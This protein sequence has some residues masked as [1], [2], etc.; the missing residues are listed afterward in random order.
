MKK[1][2]IVMIFGKRKGD[3]LTAVH[4]IQN[5][6]HEQVKN[7]SDRHREKRKAVQWQA[8][9]DKHGESYCK[10][11]RKYCFSQRQVVLQVDNKAVISQSYDTLSYGCFITNN[12]PRPTFL[13]HLLRGHPIAKLPSAHD[14][15]QSLVH[16]HF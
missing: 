16:P 8:W 3:Y 6:C 12:G 2:S 13:S 7:F 5:F 15:S 9:E 11:N 10:V 4:T 14:S 1:V